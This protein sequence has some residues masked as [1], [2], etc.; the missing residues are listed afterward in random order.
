MDT[1]CLPARIESLMQ[2]RDFV[3]GKLSEGNVA[4]ALFP[5][6]ELVLEEVLTNVFYYAYADGRGEAE[7]ACELQGDLLRLTVAD[8]GSPFNP[9]DS[10]EPNLTDDISERTVGGLGIYFVREMVQD[11]AYERRDGRNILTMSINVGH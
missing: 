6:I 11:I 5:K 2:F 1:L 7:L 9:L 4:K 3:F 10:P 8:R